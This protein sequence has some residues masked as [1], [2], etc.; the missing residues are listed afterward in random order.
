MRA[1]AVTDEVT[2]GGSGLGA[3]GWPLLVYG[4]RVGVW[5]PDRVDS[6]DKTGGEMWYLEACCWH[7]R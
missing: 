3:D 7:E 4:D 6:A 5:K 2:V 1:E